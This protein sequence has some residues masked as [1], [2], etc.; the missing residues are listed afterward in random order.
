MRAKGSASPAA[1]AVCQTISTRPS[2]RGSPHRQQ[3][4]LAAV[5]RTSGSEEAGRQRSFVGATVIVPID[6]L[7]WPVSITL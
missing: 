6:N 7:W 3:A 2:E 5:H 1:A 4:P